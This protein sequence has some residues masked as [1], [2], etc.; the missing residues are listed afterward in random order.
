MPAKVTPLRKG[1]P[2]HSEPPTPPPPP[3]E[4]P[5]PRLLSV[6]QVFDRVFRDMTGAI[7]DHGGREWFKRL[8]EKQPGVFLKCYTQLAIA[9][10]KEPDNIGLQIIVQALTVENVQ[11]VAGVLASPIAGHVM[12][13]PAPD[14]V[15][16]K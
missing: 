7:E 13:L 6:Q 4:G 3:P 1:G 12:Q 16:A 14:P 11:P 9:R 2:P 10:A 5:E 8:A 15:P